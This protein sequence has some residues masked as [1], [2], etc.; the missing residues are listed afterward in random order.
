MNFKKIS[1]DKEEAKAIEVNIDNIDSWSRASI[2]KSKSFI[3]KNK[4]EL[5]SIEI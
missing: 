4:Q 2:N 5:D 3:A 1:R